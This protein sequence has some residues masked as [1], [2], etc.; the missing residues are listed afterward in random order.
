MQYEGVWPTHHQDLLQVT[1]FDSEYLVLA[2]VQ[3]ANGVDL[4]ELEHENGT[5][6]LH[7][8]LILIDG[9]LLISE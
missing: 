9:Q 8:T 1:L 5:V 4:A 2:R 7:G 3:S 6:S